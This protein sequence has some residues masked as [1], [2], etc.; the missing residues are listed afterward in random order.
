MANKKTHK[1]IV[2]AHR[3]ACGYLPEHTL[4]SKAMAHAM[5]A[6]FLEQDVVL[7]KDEVPIVLHDKQLDST[8]DVAEKFPGRARSDGHFYALDFELEEIKQLAVGERTQTDSAGRRLAVYAER[9]PSEHALFQVPTLAEEIDLI[10]GLDRS[11]GTKTG[12]YIELKSPNWHL[13]Q[14]SDL[15]AAI[16]GV[17][18]D[19]GYAQ[20]RDQVYLQCFDDKTLRHLRKDMRTALPL[21]Q[22][23]GDN[24]W[25][26][27]S[28]V[29]YNYLRSAK[30]LADIATYADGIGP[31]IPHI[32]E[33]LQSNGHAKLSDLT[34]LAHNHGLFVHPYTF[35]RD[36]LPAGIDSFDALLD[37]FLQQ[38]EV[39]GVFTD[40]P[41]LARNFID[42]LSA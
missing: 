29:D 18:E 32:Y 3:G 1:P 15:S 14:C 4:A 7:T 36:N 13:A 12:L 23:I 16:L 37:I 42:R 11:R 26:E 30:G 39:D 35:R 28:D 33:G 40:F 31:W 8:T 17:L 27:D 10:A 22:L 6:D 2:I 21:M 41:D 38:A 34:A 20:R 9:F 24:S 5:G 25:G 19:K